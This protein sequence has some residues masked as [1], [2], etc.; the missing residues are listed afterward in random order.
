MCYSPPSIRMEIV[1]TKLPL[2]PMMSMP[3]SRNGASFLPISKWNDA[4]LFSS[5][6]S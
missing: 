2:L 1:W 3:S 4:G 6:L 5:M